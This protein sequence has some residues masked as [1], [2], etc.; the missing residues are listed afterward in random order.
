MAEVQDKMSNMNLKDGGDSKRTE[1]KTK[2]NKGAVGAT[3]EFPLEKS[4]RPAYMDHRIQMFEKLK[5]EYDEF[6]AKQPREAITITMPDGSER[7]GT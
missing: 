7:L 6:V 2:K 5:A 4:P 3:S 1:K